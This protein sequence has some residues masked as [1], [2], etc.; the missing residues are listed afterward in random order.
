MLKLKGLKKSFSLPLEFSRISDCLVH[1]GEM[2]KMFT[3]KKK[4]KQRRVNKRLRNTPRQS[5][6]GEAS[7]VSRT[8]SRA[9]KVI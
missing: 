7:Q 5:V 4:K 1:Q 3:K 9:E 8:L 6:L 2:R